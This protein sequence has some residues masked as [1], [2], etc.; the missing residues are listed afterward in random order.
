MAVEQEYAIT[1]AK[2]R[3]HDKQTMI[4]R[5]A[6]GEGEVEGEKF[7]IGTDVATGSPVW[8]FEKEARYY[9]VS[10]RA[11]TEDVLDARAGLKSSPEEVK[12]K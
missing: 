11:L 5:L 12:T 7:S 8:Y 10:L 3:Q 1:K 6:V 2:V 9:T 4:L